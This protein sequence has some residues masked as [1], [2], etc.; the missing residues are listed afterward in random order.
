MTSAPTPFTAEL[1]RVADMQTR[2]QLLAAESVLAHLSGRAPLRI[3]RVTLQDVQYAIAPDPQAMQ[4]N[5]GLL[6]DVVMTAL[7][8][9]EVATLLKVPTVQTDSGRDAAALLRA[10]L[11]EPDEQAV[12]AEYLRVLRA[13]ARA[14]LRRS[15]AEIQVVAAGLLEH[16]E[17]DA[18][19]LRYRVQCAQGIRGT[20]MN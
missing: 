19:A 7:A 14:A 20:L 17:L 5:R 15:W 6:E 18:E 13:R 9:Q 3:E 12:S 16:G 4:S 2:A 10:G 11:T 1:A 8:Q